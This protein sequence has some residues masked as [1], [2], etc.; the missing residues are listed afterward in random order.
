V[1]TVRDIADDCDAV[2]KTFSARG[3]ATTVSDATPVVTVFLRNRG[4][5]LALRRAES[6]ET[7]PGRWAGVSGYVESGEDPEATARREIEEET[8]LA[9]A[10]AADADVHRVRAGRPFAVD[11][12]EGHVEVHPFLF[13]AD[14]REIE[15]NEETVQTAWLHPTELLRRETV[16]DLWHSYQSVAP[17]VKSVAADAEHGAAYV[18]LRALEVLRDRAGLL[19]GTDAER[20][21]AWD[22]L[23]DL[24]RRLRTARPSMA[25]LQNRV[26]RAMAVAVAGNDDYPSPAAVERAAIDAIEDAIDAEETT[27]TTAAEV[28]AGETVLTLSRS[29]TLLAA[30]ERAATDREPPER[31]FVAE[32]RPAR[33]GVDVAEALAE[34]FPVTLTTDAAVGHVLA[35]YDVERVVVGA[36]SLLPDGRVINKT[37]TRTLATV[38][39]RAG[40]PV[41]V[42]AASD[43]LR[44]DGE[45]TLESGTP[46]AVYD[47]DAPIDVLNPTFDVTPADRITAVVTE[48]GVLDPADL[49][50]LAAERAGCSTWS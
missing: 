25:V 34:E 36:D 22:E 42:V 12:E 38:A 6:V 11:D 39:D 46:S 21:T 17:T 30:F 44:S 49:A 41:D 35:E 7:Y 43:K 40:V 31:L 32:S 27:A 24:A 2:D 33:E 19:V 14:T 16:T 28:L 50:D 48:R 47:G 23:A 1:V 5:V 3:V 45:Y 18:S 29:G 20:E 4:Q 15:T 37:G 26:D 13:D 9:A 10:P 8:G